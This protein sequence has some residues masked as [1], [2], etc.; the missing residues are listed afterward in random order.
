MTDKTADVRRLADLDAADEE[1]DGIAAARALLGAHFGATPLVPA[2]SLSSPGRSVYLKN[3]TALPTG[4]F[5]IRG[6]IYALQASLA[7]GTVKEVV[8]A[9]TGNHGAA[10]AYAAKLLGI[11]ARIFLP[12]DSNPVKVARVREFGATLVAEGRDLSAAIDAAARYVALTGAFFLNDASD[13]DIPLGAATIGAEIVEQLPSVNVVFVP[14]G[15]TALI[16]G[17]ASALKRS[18]RPIR[19]I[20]VVAE[21]APAYYLSW[22]SGRVVETE[23]AAT[24][25]DGLAVTRPLAPNVSAI[26]RLVD[27]V[28]TVT[29]DEMIDAIARLRSGEGILAEPS[30][31]A[32]VAALLRDTDRTG[33]CVAL[34]TGG[35]ISPDVERRVVVER[36]HEDRAGIR[37]PT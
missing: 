13:P 15:D 33:A 6:A 3:E 26:R 16:R 1:T 25:A 29:E 31:A 37:I 2:A 14:M 7:Q 8:A 20:G 27:E 5:K 9:S 34:V 10:V 18:G 19:I 30:G 12:R 35:N 28:V 11:P 21:A 24:I 36:A 23:S 22:Q 32:A 17:V 4:S